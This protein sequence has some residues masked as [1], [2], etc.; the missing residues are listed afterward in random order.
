MS[1]RARAQ[2]KIE[3][4]RWVRQR[5]NKPFRIHELTKWLHHQGFQRTAPGGD[6]TV[7][8]VS[9]WF[10][11]LTAKPVYCEGFELEGLQ[12]GRHRH[13]Y[14]W[15]PGQPTLNQA[16]LMKLDAKRQED[17]SKE[18]ST[19]DLPPTRPIVVPL[20]FNKR[21]VSPLLETLKTILDLW[22]EAD[23][24]S[25]EEYAKEAIKAIEGG[26]T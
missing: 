9:H 4:A 1:S 26:L 22:E 11:E 2:W 14:I 15:R 8:T 23:T 3:A 12:Y 25:F 7:N 16:A 13:T 19:M 21:E 6:L 20:P 17:A 18:L 10:S 24:E 5:P